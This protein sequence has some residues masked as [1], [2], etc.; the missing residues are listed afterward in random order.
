MNRVKLRSTKYGN[1]FDVDN[2]MDTRLEYLSG[3]SA[4]H[5]SINLPLGRVFMSGEE[6]ELS[7]PE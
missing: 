4:G 5:V 1:V 7:I 3:L 2:K 6:A